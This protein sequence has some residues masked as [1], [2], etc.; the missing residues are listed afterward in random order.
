MQQK[1][2]I[3]DGYSTEFKF[4]FILLTICALSLKTHN[5]IFDD[6]LLAA[7]G[8]FYLL[9][10][11][12]FLL[13]GYFVTKAKNSAVW[14]FIFKSIS[15]LLWSMLFSF[16]FS[17]SLDIPNTYRLIGRI[18]GIDF[19]SVVASSIRQDLGGF[20]THVD[21]SCVL[22]WLVF[23][24]IQI[25]GCCVVFISCQYYSAQ[26]TNNENSLIRTGHLDAKKKIWYINI[27]VPE[28]DQ[29][30]QKAWS[31]QFSFLIVPVIFLILT[32][33]VSIYSVTFLNPT[34]GL[35][36]LILFTLGIY[37]WILAGRNIALVRML[38]DFEKDGVGRIGL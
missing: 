12:V 2:E 34:L 32:V 11:G 3:Q 16:A 6:S 24:M 13:I 7:S 29:K 1:K 4:T 21:N 17:N 10:V 5:R 35:F 20:G 31:P 28:Q 26:G 15:F 27:D 37:C 25:I 23:L 14:Y 9:L 18:T 36:S 22:F 8:F 38:V 30:K 33:L 19:P